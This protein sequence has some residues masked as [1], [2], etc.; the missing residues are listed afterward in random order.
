MSWF[1]TGAWLEKETL[2]AALALEYYPPGPKD[3]SP[4]Q[5]LLLPD[6]VLTGDLDA[7][8]TSAR[9]RA[10]CAATCSTRRSTPTTPT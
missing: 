1:H 4:P 3:G 9:R 6:T 5:A 8:R 2:E 7:S 10:R